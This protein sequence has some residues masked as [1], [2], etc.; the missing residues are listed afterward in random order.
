[1]I[2]KL[3]FKTLSSLFLVYAFLVNPVFAEDPPDLPEL[4]PIVYEAL[5]FLFSFMVIVTAAMV[6]Y[7]AYMWMLSAGDPQ[8]VKQAQGTLTW[9]IIG[10][11]F[12]I[13]VRVFLDFILKLFGV[14][15]PDPGGT[16]F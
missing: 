5:K 10:L 13:M 4:F 14:T 2:K 15:L 1:M 3:F 12:F 7:G 8:K 6:V 11:I 16:P 9:A